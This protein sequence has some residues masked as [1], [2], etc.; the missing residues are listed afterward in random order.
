VDQANNRPV[1]TY[2]YYDSEIAADA[3]ESGSLDTAKELVIK[4]RL[5]HEQGGQKEP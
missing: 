5:Q 4:D 1:A 2:W 3:A